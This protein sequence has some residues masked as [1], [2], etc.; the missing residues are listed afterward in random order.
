MSEEGQSD[1]FTVPFTRQELKFVLRKCKA[2]KAPGADEIPNEFLTHQGGIGKRKLLE[3]I[4]RTWSDGVLPKLWRQ[5]VVVPILKKNQDPGQASSYRPISLTSCVG[6][7][8]E[9]LINRRLVR[10]LENNELI[11]PGQAGFRAGRN[12]VDQVTCLLQRMADGFQMREST[13]AVFIDF[14]QA[15]DRVWRPGLFL[16]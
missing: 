1:T 8:A 7:V 5:A 14:K 3:F 9:R 6:K 4:N 11:T 2:R 16:L 13:L 15:Y 12:S 10:Y